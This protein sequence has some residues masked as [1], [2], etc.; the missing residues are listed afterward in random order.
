M[1]VKINSA[2]EAKKLC[3]E[4]WDAIDNFIDDMK[5]APFYFRVDRNTR[6]YDMINIKK[7][8]AGHNEWACI[9]PLCEFHLD[10]SDRYHSD[11]CRGCPL[12][13]VR[14]KHSLSCI[15]MG[16]D[17]CMTKTEIRQFIKVLRERLGD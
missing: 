16:Y 8:V 6:R 5:C 2:K 7:A 15:N 10:T 4:L 3:L 11:A 13:G 1:K 14:G 12:D 17:D 9:C